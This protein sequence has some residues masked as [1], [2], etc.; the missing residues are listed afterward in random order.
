[1]EE[2]Q[3]SEKINNQKTALKNWKEEL[4]RDLKKKDEF[5]DLYIKSKEWLD[6]YE[7]SVFENE[8]SLENYKNF[9]LIDNNKLTN[10]HSMIESP[11]IF[12]L[13]ELTWNSLVRNQ[14]KEKQIKVFG[15]YNKN[16]LIFYFKQEE[17]IISFY[18]LDEKEELRQGYIKIYRI[19]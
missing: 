9:K 15:C 8:K 12:P 1:M 11:S 18:F 5:R 7:K 3:I 4:K 2:K 13:N 6:G 10:S 19:N 14:A 17:R 16:V